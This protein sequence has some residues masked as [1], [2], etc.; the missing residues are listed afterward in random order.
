MKLYATVTSER[1]Q[2]SQGGKFLDIEVSG[3]KGERVAELDVRDQGDLY[4]LRLQWG[5]EKYEVRIQKGNKQKDKTLD[6]EKFAELVDRNATPE[7]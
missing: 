6:M 2:G 4:L 3:N 5:K 1:A 7:Q